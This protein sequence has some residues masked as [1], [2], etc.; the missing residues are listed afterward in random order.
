[1]AR[2]A[3]IQKQRGARIVKIEEP[4]EGSVD[5]APSSSGRSS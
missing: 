4:P 5:A 2:A 3:R 1:M